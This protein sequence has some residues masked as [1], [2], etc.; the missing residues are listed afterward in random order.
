MLFQA[1]RSSQ[2]YE[3]VMDVLSR[4]AHKSG[5]KGANELLGMWEED[6]SDRLTASTGRRDQRDYDIPRPK[7]KSGSHRQAKDNH[8]KESI[9][10]AML[11]S[12][13]PKTTGGGQKR[14]VSFFDPENTG[15]PR[16]RTRVTAV[17]HAKAHGVSESLAKERLE[18]GQCAICGSADH[19]ARRCPR[20]SQTNVH[21]RPTDDS[22]GER[23]ET[24]LL[25]LGKAEVLAGTVEVSP[26]N[27]DPGTTYVTHARAG[28]DTMCSQNLVSRG[29]VSMLKVTPTSGEC[30]KLQ[31]AG[32]AREAQEWVTLTVKRPGFQVQLQLLVVDS[33]PEIDLL[34]RKADLPSLG[35]QIIDHAPQEEPADPV[36]RAQK[37]LADCLD[38][39]IPLPGAPKYRSRLRRLRAGEHKDDPKQIYVFEID[40]DDVRLE[41]KRLNEYQRFSR[42]AN[43]D[44]SVPMLNRLSAEETSS[45]TEELNGMIDRR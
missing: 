42:R 16:K 1:V 45:Y 2:S 24:A 28:F 33:L 6:R 15:P 21:D 39:W 30:V 7:F 5:Y 32:G 41:G 43:I 3:E 11:S 13:A 10:R 31:T 38:V 26:T 20:N 4:H 35:Y 37:A 40:W 22:K 34:V 29:L 19:F 23:T 27:N 18:K 44:Y 36:T 8:G 12:R 25:T 9:P 17:D 14:P